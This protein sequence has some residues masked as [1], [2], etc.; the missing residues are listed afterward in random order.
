MCTLLSARGYAVIILKHI[1]LV[2]VFAYGVI[3]ILGLRCL[4]ARTTEE[5]PGVMARQLIIA[6]R[7]YMFI[8]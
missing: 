4:D 8:T 6:E 1:C 3:K 2:G 5:R 7:H